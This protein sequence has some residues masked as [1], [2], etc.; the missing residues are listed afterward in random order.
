[1]DLPKYYHYYAGLALALSIT[2][3]FTDVLKVREFYTSY[4]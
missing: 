3:M 4:F 2:I 1:M